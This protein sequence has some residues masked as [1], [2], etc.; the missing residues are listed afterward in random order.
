M[1]PPLFFV[2]VASKRL[3]HTVS[4]LFAAFGRYGKIFEELEGPRGGGTGRL[5]NSRLE[6]RKYGLGQKRNWEIGGSGAWQTHNR[7][8][9]SSLLVNV[10]VGYHSNGTGRC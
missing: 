4:L 5:R 8:A 6:E 10:F 9:G 3:S 1:Y 2:N 7:I